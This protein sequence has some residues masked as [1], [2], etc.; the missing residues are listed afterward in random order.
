MT[1]KTPCIPWDERRLG[2]IIPTA[3][4]KDSSGKLDAGRGSTKSSNFCRVGK[5]VRRRIHMSDGV[6]C[7][8]GPQ[9]VLYRWARSLGDGFGHWV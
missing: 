7:F 3:V 9:N 5:L 1:W 2:E 6:F 4:A 8:G